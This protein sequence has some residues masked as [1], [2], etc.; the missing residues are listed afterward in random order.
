MGPRLSGRSVARCLLLLCLPLL[1]QCDRVSGDNPARQ[2]IDLA[3][4]IEAREA[5][6][7][8]EIP[9]RIEELRV[10][11]G[12]VVSKGQVV[13]LLD[14]YD[15]EVA[16]ARAVAEAAAARAVL[17]ALKAGTRVQEIRAAEAE[18]AYARAQVK[19]AATEV[20]R[21]ARLIQDQLASQE[22]HDQALIGADL[23]RA[24]LKKATE[25][26]LLLREG[27]R[28]EDIDRAAAEL[29]ARERAVDT[30]R[31]RLDKAQLKSPIAGIVSVRLSDRG[32]VVAE[33]TPVFRIAELSLP[34]VRA[35]L[36]GQDLARVTLGQQAEVRADGLPGEVF[37]GRLSFISPEAEFTPKTVETRELRTDLVY[38]IKID[39]ENPDG[40]LKIGMPVDVSMA[41]AV[42]K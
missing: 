11:E 12:D 34:W 4:T 17:A 41:P 35:Y 16:L 31:R 30:A 20:E 9:G 6:L 22:Q 21:A 10:D 25:N 5:D 29:E 38:R 40:L 24:N 15:Y 19:F 3:G 27:P 32:E 37:A 18:V 2:V 33:G 26:L 28:R 36:N 23:A 1:G 39:V 42:S 14:P 8:F 7:A 13:A